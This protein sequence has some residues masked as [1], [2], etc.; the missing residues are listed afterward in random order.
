[1]KP[2]ANKYM[3]SRLSLKQRGL[4]AVEAVVVLPVL[5]LSL[6]A[7]V[8]I[9]NAI[10]HYN[11]LTQA[12]SQGARYLAGV[13]LGTGG[14]VDISAQDIT[15]T[16]QLVAY[17][18]VGTGTAILPGFTPSDVTVQDLGDGDISVT[19]NYEYQSL[20]L[21]GAPNVITGTRILETF[22]MSA[23][24]VMSLIAR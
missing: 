8:E 12:V 17:G 24:T 20:I 4:A 19:A 2:L 1:M 6:F 11:T 3:Y 9:G 21:G 5:L 10:L 18:V 22:T 15:N 7:T 23:G 13:P 14:G 16:T